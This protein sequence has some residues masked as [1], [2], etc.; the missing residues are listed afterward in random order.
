MPQTGSSGREITIS[1]RPPFRPSGL[2][3]VQY[4]STGLYSWLSHSRALPAWHAIDYG[5]DVIIAGQGNM[6]G[7]SI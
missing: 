4:S 2:T 6:L 7:I 5:A 3:T 1:S